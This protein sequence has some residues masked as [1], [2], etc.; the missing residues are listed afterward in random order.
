[1]KGALCFHTELPCVG[2]PQAPRVGTVSTQTWTVR[3]A[4]RMLARS[5]PT[6]S[7]KTSPKP[8]AE[9][10]AGPQPP[11]P[12]QSPCRFT[13]MSLFPEPAVLQ[14][15][16]PHSGQ[17]GCPP[18]VLSSVYRRGFWWA[19]RK[20]KVSLPVGSEA[21]ASATPSLPSETV[22]LRGGVSRPGDIRLSLDKSKN[23]TGR[24]LCKKT[25]D[26]GL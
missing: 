2:A 13:V 4:R 5:Y 26:L 24:T 3:H 8:P 6:L 15:P 20:A 23:I 9:R 19:A 22:W 12:S 18:A 16:G 1:M 17:A 7:T 21:G 25:A 14:A 10:S 11:S